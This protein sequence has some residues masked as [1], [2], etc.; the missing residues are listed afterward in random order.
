MKTGTFGPGASDAPLRSLQLWVPAYFWSDHADRCPCDDPETDMATEV[1]E[2]GRRVLI[3]ATPKQ[4]EVLRSDAA[5]YCDRDG[6]DECP[7]GLVRSARA[8]LAAIAK[9]LG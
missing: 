8:T 6:P 9:A 2:A 7:P 3:E 4:L 5:F 1:R